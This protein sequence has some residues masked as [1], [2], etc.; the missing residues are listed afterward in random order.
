MKIAVISIN[1]DYRIHAAE[2]A[3]VAREVKKSDAGAWT[4]DVED[5][6]TL[7]IECWGDVASDN[8]EENTPEWLAYIGECAS[9]CSK[10]L[11][12]ASALP[13]RK[14]G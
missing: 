6:R 9:A 8:H 7:D 2:C 1:G 3:D 10:Y 4:V 13:E 11:P 12:C 14:E 5:R